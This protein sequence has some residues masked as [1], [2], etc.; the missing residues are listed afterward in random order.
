MSPAL[1]PRCSDGLQ[2]LQRLTN[3]GA[4]FVDELS[5]GWPGLTDVDRVVVPGAVRVARQIR[6]KDL[7]GTERMLNLNCVMPQ[8]WHRGC[9]CGDLRVVVA[10]IT[11]ADVLVV[12]GPSDRVR[13]LAICKL[14][15]CPGEATGRIAEG[16]KHRKRRAA[17]RNSRL[18]SHFLAGEQV[19]V[20]RNHGGKHR[21]HRPN[22]GSKFRARQ[23]APQT[24][25]AME[26]RPSPDAARKTAGVTIHG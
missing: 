12:R 15:D 18:A 17:R 7:K 3:C 24:S 1:D 6:V 22:P 25:H 23:G 10:E 14:L 21:T 11:N 19:E 16:W 20:D 9:K 2:S 13:R 4:R 8:L 5:A 26:F